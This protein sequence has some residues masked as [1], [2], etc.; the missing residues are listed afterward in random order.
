MNTKLFIIL[1]TTALFVLSC[2]TIDMERN[3]IDTGAGSI[4]RTA[5]NAE[6]DNA[7]E[8]SVEENP[9][10]ALFRPPPPQ[11][12][13]VERP[14]F[15][16]EGTTPSPARVVTGGDAVREAA[17]QGVRQPSEYSQAAMVYD[18]H[19]DWVYQVYTQ[20]LRVSSLRL[21]PGERVVDTPFVSDSERWFLGAGYNY[22]NGMPVQHIYVR[23]SVHSIQASLIINTDR[24]VYNILLKS[25]QNTYMP[26]TRWRYPSTGLPNNYIEAVQSLAR[27]SLATQGGVASATESNESGI[28]LD[29]RFLSF[30]YRITYSRMRRPQWMPEQVFDDGRQTYIVLPKGVLQARMPAAFDERR[31]VINSRV[32]EHVIILDRLVEKITLRLDNRSAVI[33]KKRM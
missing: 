9:L 8:N 18:Y 2:K 28:V 3:V 6:S 19:S 5:R 33:E 27:Q 26:M 23:P 13:I 15:I 24:R 14:V 21:E 4:P 29:P 31:N 1:T 30:N 22:E 10:A 20:P 25:F 16:P 7:G 11:V 12:I 17:S 32:H